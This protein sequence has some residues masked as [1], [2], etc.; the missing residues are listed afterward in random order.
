MLKGCEHFAGL[1][2]DAEDDIQAAIE[3]AAESAQASEDGKESP[4]SI[5]FTVK[6]DL[7]RNKQTGKI[8]V[9][10]RKTHETE[11]PMPDP[12]QPELL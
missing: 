12:S 2:A 7:N 1:F 5:S 3:A 8:A 10:I 9:A 11:S 4:V 6:L